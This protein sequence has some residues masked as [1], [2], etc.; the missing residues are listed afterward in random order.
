MLAGWMHPYSIFVASYLRKYIGR[1]LTITL[2]NLCISVVPMLHVRQITLFLILSLRPWD[3]NTLL[4]LS[5]G[6]QITCSCIWK[7]SALYFQVVMAITGVAGMH[8]NKSERE[9]MLE[10]RGSSSQRCSNSSLVLTAVQ[11]YS[12]GTHLACQEKKQQTE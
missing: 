12:K 2:L 10:E 8:C 11:E 9:M 5:Q 6:C 3:M 4:E 7:C 1:G